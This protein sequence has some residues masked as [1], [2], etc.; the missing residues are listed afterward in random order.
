MEAG[1]ITASGLVYLFGDR[2]VKEGP[3]FLVRCV[4]GPHQTRSKGR[5]EVTQ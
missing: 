4:G 3:V 2:F 5:G 1:L